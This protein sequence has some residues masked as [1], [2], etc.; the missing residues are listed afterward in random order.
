MQLREVNNYI[1]DRVLQTITTIQNTADDA[2][3]VRKLARNLELELREWI[4][5]K[6]TKVD[7]SISKQ[8]E[9]IIRSVEEEFDESIEYVSTGDISPNILGDDKTRAIL[10]ACTQALIN[11]LSHGKPPY[12]V[13][14]S[15]KQ[16]KIEIF[17]RDHGDGFDIKSIP[18]LHYGVKE[19]IIQRIKDVGGEVKI[20]SEIKTDNL[21]DIDTKNFGTEVSI[22]IKL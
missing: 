14:L 7:E 8:L 9:M 17:I 13:M 5:G 15:A 4:S 20:R 19:S 6:N 2:K 11:A 10:N 22:C 12:N 3:T 21:A 18:D 1:H 16:S